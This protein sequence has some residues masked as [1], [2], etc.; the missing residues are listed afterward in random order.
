MSAACVPWY[1]PRCNMGLSKHGDPVFPHFCPL[2]QNLAR[3]GT[4]GR[5]GG[6]RS[7]GLSLAQRQAVLYLGVFPVSLS[8]YL[9]L[10]YCTR[11]L[12]LA[13]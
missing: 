5:G 9:T 11:L 3:V 7:K 12:A 13:V 2:N 4:G 10:L 1:V 6:G 8:L